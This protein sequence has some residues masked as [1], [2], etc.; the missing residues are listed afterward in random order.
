MC[1]YG[2]FMTLLKILC[3]ETA[4]D[5]PMTIKQFLTRMREEGTPITEKTVY[6]YFDAMRDGGVIVGKRKKN[7]PYN[8]YWYESGWI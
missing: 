7:Y 2:I 8:E 4:P 5:D 1:N 6:R 3:N